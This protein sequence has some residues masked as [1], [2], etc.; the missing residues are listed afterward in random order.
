MTLLSYERYCGELLTQTDLL[1][2]CVA[3]ADMRAPVPGC[4]GWNL[5]QLLRHVGAAYRWAE[6]AVRTRA[7]DAVPHGLV[8]DVAGY[9]DEK[10]E[11]LDAWLAEGASRLAGTLRAAGPGTPVWTPGP[12]GT[13]LFW[14][15]RML[16]ET[17]VHRAD[18]ARA[19]GAGYALGEDVALDAVDE[20][21]GFGSVPEVVEPRAG[22]PALLGP[23]R[24]LHF[25]A[26]GT[27]AEGSSG[28]ASGTAADGS[29]GAAPGAAAEWLVDLTGDAVVCR[30]AHEEA[31]VAVRAPLTD[32]VLLLYRRR[33]AADDGIEVHGDAALLDLWLERSGFWLRE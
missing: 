25:H 28:A 15:R 30:R 20:W 22:A 10:A 8:D 12:G 32:L 26:T 27:A 29:S 21:M 33:T 9:A 7:T 3:G 6:T 13:A 19:A 5:S 11:V 2:S 24:T 16:H 18:A 31:A 23:G 17:V 1:R 4:P 14:A